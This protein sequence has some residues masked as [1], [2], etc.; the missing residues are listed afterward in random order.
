[1]LAAPASASEAE[2]VL[3]AGSSNQDREE[4]LSQIAGAFAV[5]APLALVLATGV[6]Y[7][8]ARRALRPVEA[9]RARAEG[10]GGGAGGERLPLPEAKD[11][12]RALGL[13]LNS[14]LARLEGALE[15][16]KGFVADAGHELRTPLSILRAELELAQRE[17]RSPEELRAAIGSALGE[18]DRLARLADDLLVAARADRGEI[19]IRREIVDVDELLGRV[20]NRYEGS[21]ARAGRR[22]ES[23]S[24]G[25]LRASIDPLRAEQAIGNLLDNALRHGAGTVTINARLADG[26]LA[27]EVRDAGR[28]FPAGFRE[29]AFERFSRADPGRSG[30]GAGLG[31]AIVAAIARAHG[32]TA[33]LPPAESG[34]GAA[35]RLSFGPESSPAYE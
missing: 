34:S 18:V 7:L 9:M 16:E 15:R 20:V 1:V 17:G 29:H 21:A 25:R 27:V 33:T 10:I 12:L 5:G 23:S 31:L 35:V 14:M 19:P 28:G 11:E 26:E 30:A 3:V 22:V 32:G 24:D 4:T 6:G 8:L 2:L 13:T